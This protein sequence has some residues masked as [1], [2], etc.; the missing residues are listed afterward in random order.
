MKR[1]IL[2]A[3]LI[4]ATAFAQAQ[5]TKLVQLKYADP[6]SL[7]GVIR[8]FGVEMN[9]TSTAVALGGPTENV[10][11]AELAIKQLDVS[12]K[13]VELIVHFVVGSD[14]ANLSGA[15]SLPTCAM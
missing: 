15:P 10:N 9:W 2:A 7:V 11:A 8:T 4:A 12:P 6:Q 3:L 1:L 5:V 13:T 14:Q